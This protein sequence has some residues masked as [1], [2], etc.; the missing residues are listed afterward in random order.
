M[1]GTTLVKLL[2]DLRAETR[3]SLNPAHN[4]QVR[5][6]QVKRLQ[7]VQERMWDD[8]DWPHLRVERQFD[9]QAG[10]R[11][12]APPSDMTV[13]RIGRVEIYADGR[14][15]PVLPNIGSEHYSAYNSDLDERAWPPRRWQIHEDGTIELWPIPELN[16]DPETLEGRVK[17]TGIRNLRPLVNDG[18]VAD[19]DDRTIVLY[20]A[21]EL[22]AGAGAKDAQLK[23]QAASKREAKLRGQLS[24]RRTVKMFGLGKSTTPRRFAPHYRPPEG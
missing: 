24:P 14:W 2:D 8:F 13:D 19:L 22:L 23:L 17:L 21:G 12:Y 10:Q 6:S 3:V 4:A 7:S 16:A 1:R 9:T 5:D 11:Y 20:A 15:Q 18:D